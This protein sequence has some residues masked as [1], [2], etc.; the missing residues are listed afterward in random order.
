MRNVELYIEIFPELL[1]ISNFVDYLDSNMFKTST[2][3]LKYT[4][5]IEDQQTDR[6]AAQNIT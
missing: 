2:M 5:V 1:E 4:L 6:I 3:E